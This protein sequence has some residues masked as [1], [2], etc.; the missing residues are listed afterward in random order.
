[1]LQILGEVLSAAT[2][3]LIV[4]ELPKEILCWKVGSN[5]QPDTTSGTHRQTDCVTPEVSA[6]DLDVL[7]DDVNGLADILGR[8]SFGPPFLERGDQLV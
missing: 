6:M 8:S 4:L 7:Q 3:P 1:L 5:H 2:P